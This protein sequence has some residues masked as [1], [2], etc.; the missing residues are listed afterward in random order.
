MAAVA[1]QSHKIVS[2][3]VKENQGLL[4]SPYG[5][6]QMSVWSTPVP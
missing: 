1:I 2:D 6:T 3:E 4:E 5:R